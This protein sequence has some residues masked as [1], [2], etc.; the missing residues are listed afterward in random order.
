MVKEDDKI[1]LIDDDG[2][3]FI[4]TI[5]LI[6]DDKYYINI[7]DN[8][9]IFELVD[10]YLKRNNKLY[11]CKEYFIE[12]NFIKINFYL[13]D[14]EGS[15]FLSKKLIYKILEFNDCECGICLNIKIIKL[16]NFLNTYSFENEIEMH[17]KNFILNKLLIDL[18][19]LKIQDLD[20]YIEN[21]N[22]Q[23]LVSKV[24]NLKTNYNKSIHLHNTCCI[25]LDEIEDSNKIII[26]CPTCNHIF[27]LEDCFERFIENDNKCPYCRINLE[28]WIKID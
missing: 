25:C 22:N 8:I 20:N 5:D 16:C 27:C 10:I 9:L 6:D 12:N 17:L 19:N 13:E 15:N 28:S 23:N 3:K 2:I 18:I 24:L 26:N 4:G 14:L 1:L 21:L 11:Y 7:N